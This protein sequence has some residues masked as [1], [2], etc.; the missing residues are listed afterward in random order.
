VGRL[1]PAKNHGRLLE[2][3]AAIRNGSPSSWLLVVG[4]GTDNPEGEV[5]RAVG[6]LGIEDRVLFLGFRTDVPRLLKASDALLLP[7]RWEG[8]PGVVLEACAAGLPVLATDLPGVREIASRLEGVRSLPLSASD[9]Q[10]AAAAEQVVTDARRRRPGG[11]ALEAFRAS[12]FH[13]DHAVQAHCELWTAA[14]QNER[15]GEAAP[16][17][18]G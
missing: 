12:V 17:Q 14:S 15:A 3:F 4:E 16:L 18:A 2:I 9:A 8:L 7:S 13:I 5:V 6:R 10:W 1:A 11:K